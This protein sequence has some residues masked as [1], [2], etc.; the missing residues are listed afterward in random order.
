MSIRSIETSCIARERVW[1]ISGCWL[2]RSE[3]TGAQADPNIEVGE[4]D[5][6]IEASE[7]GAAAQADTNIGVGA[8]AQADANIEVG[9]GAPI[10]MGDRLAKCR[11]TR[12]R[13]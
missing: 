5:A 2:I 11:P 4:A 12:V 3:R 7:V 8:G 13:V 9:A 1:I 6:S 10:Q